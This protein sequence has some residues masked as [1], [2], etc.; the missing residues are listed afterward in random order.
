MTPSPQLVAHKTHLLQE[1]VNLWK[2]GHI[3]LRFGDESHVCTSG[4]VPYGWMFPDEDVYIPVQKEHPLSIFGMVSPDCVYDGL[5]TVESINSEMLADY[6]DGFSLMVA[7]PT[8]LVL[9]N[10]S[11]HRKGKVARM[12]QVWEERGLY[13]FF[14]PPYCP[15]LNIAETVW[16]ILKGKWLQPHHYC[17]KE[18]LHETTREILAGIGTDYVINFSHAA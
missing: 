7:K 14:L 18:T 9:D 2:Q 8:V 16:R 3:D 12:R 4:Y 10:A 13:L 1:L 5:E 6:L 17:C 11:I 15:H